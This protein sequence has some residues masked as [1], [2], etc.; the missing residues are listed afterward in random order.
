MNDLQIRIANELKSRY[1]KDEMM[2]SCKSIVVPRFFMLN[3]PDIVDN[4]ESMG[5]NQKTCWSKL[6]S[7][8]DLNSSQLTDIILSSFGYYNGGNEIYINTNTNS[9]VSKD[10]VMIWTATPTKIQLDKL[11]KLFKKTLGPREIG[12]AHV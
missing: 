9:I 3:L 5:D 4:Q 11:E 7:D 2:S 10:C 6:M 12:R 8:V 1:T